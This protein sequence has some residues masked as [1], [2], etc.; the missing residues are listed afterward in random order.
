M[1]SGSDRDSV[2]HRRA[3]PYLGAAF[4]A[5]A[6]AAMQTN[7]ALLNLAGVTLPSFSPPISSVSPLKPSSF[8]AFAS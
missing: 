1:I 2:N 3:S 5:E 6:F 4:D 7:G 8:P